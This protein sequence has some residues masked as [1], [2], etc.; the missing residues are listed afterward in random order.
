MQELIEKW[1]LNKELLAS[2]INMPVGTFYNKIST[3]HS[4]SFS[5]EEIIKLKGVLREMSADIDGV[6][7][8]EFNDALKVILE[9]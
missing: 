5:D 2:K 3:K 1:K 8:I 4:S 9:K 7:E 6:T